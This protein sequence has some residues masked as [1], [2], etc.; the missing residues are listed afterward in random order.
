MEKNLPENKT[1]IDKR[2]KPRGLIDNKQ[3]LWK[4][5]SKNEGKE[6]VHLDDRRE[7]RIVERLKS[8]GWNSPAV[9]AKRSLSRITAESK[10][11]ERKSR[12]PENE[13]EAGINLPSAIRDAQGKG[14]TSLKF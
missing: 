1:K 4:M 6:I 11:A 7:F 14:A 3:E 10:K 2:I 12:S 9:A 8:S 13:N 5:S